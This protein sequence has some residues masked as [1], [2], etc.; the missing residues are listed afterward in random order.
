MRIQTKETGFTLVELMVTLAVLAVIA[1]IAVPGLSGLVRDSRLSSQS[2]G[3]VTAL[4]L[5][6]QEAIQ[7]REDVKLCPVATTATADNATGCASSTNWNQG[8]L[9][10]TSAGT[11]LHRIPAAQGISITTTSTGVI[12]TGTLGSAGTQ[13]SFSLCLPGRTPQTVTVSPSGRATKSIGS[14]TCS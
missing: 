2:D 7:Q 9:I 11:I 6:R 14:T 4:S 10:A 13:A 12:F 5:A 8:F 3:L 1:S